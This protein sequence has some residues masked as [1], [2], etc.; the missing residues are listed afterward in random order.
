MNRRGITTVLII[1]LTLLVLS[2][3]PVFAFTIPGWD[4]IKEFAGAGAWQAV[5]LAI[6]ALLGLAGLAKYTPIV[7]LFCFALG[8][9]AAVGETA[10]A[11]LKTVANYFGVAIEDGKISADEAK[12]VPVLLKAEGASIKATW[13]AMKI[14]LAALKKAKS[15]G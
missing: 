11:A 1:T 13:A 8:S 10:F 3:L 9:I 15:N 6:T 12:Q 4:K 14:A 5:A 2:A 7:S